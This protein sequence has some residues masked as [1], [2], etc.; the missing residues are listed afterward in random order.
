VP[1]HLRAFL[2]RYFSS[3]A[4]ATRRR[5]RDFCCSRHNLDLT[6]RSSMSM[7]PS[8]ICP[9]RRTRVT[10]RTQAW[11]TTSCRVVGRLP[12]GK[13]R[14][15]RCDAGLPFS[16]AAVLKDR[17]CDQWNVCF[18]CADDRGCLTALRAVLRSAWCCCRSRRR[19]AGRRGPR[20]RRCGGPVLS[21]S[22]RRRRWCSWWA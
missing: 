21:C 18:T 6:S 14:H 10:E 11:V 16:R 13:T 5:P 4:R 9:A 2:A 3:I 1:A 7:M 8:T 15:R 20:W 22:W 17:A 12:P 19:G